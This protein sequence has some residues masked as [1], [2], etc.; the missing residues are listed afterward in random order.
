MSIKNTFN[1][2]RFLLVCKQNLINNQK[3]MVFASIGFIGVVFIGLTMVQAGNDFQPLGVEIFLQMMITFMAIFGVLYIGY[4]FPS[5]RNKES[6]ISYLTMPASA[7]EKLLFEFLNRVVLSLI[8][9]PILFWIAFN[10]HGV[11]FELGTKKAFELI[12]IS[13]VLAIDISPVDEMFWA[14]A[15][16]VSCTFLVLVLPF[17]GAAIFSKQ[18]LIKS[19]F[20]IAIIL[21]SYFAVVYIV[22]EPLGLGEYEVNGELFLLPTGENSALR[23]FSIATFISVLVMLTVAYLKLKEREV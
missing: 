23:F 18:P 19:L 1:W 22:M 21:M 4:S 5:L 3:L 7:F 15:L 12:G 2:K 9:L 20:S 6:S 16:I 10:I 14:Q 8:A 17:T 11:V 13:D